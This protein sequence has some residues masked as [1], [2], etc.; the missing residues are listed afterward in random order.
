M[1]YKSFG[2]NVLKYTRDGASYIDNR[3]EN[4]W[5]ESYEMKTP[6]VAVNGDYAAIATR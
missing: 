6:V 3:G 5:T 1:G 4:V 2:N